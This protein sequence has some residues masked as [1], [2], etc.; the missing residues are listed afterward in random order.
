MTGGAAVASNVR[1]IT[2]SAK[3]TDCCGGR[4]GAATGSCTR[5]SF[6]AAWFAATFASRVRVLSTTCVT[7]AAAT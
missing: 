4:S 3:R 2:A 7:A 5:K 6:A 1:T